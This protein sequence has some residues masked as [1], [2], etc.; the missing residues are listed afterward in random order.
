MSS[1]HCAK[2]SFSFREEIQ[3]LSAN[4]YFLVSYD[5][6]QNKI[7]LKISKTEHKQLFIFATS[8]TQF[9]F[10][11]NFYD[12]IDGVSMGLHWILSCPVLA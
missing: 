3:A 7:N 2:D 11:G 10:K 5:V 12:Q 6:L 1:E 8:G 4:D 9:L